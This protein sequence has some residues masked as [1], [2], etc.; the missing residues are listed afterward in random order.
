MK[1]KTSIGKWI[2]LYIPLLSIGLA[3]LFLTPFIEPEQT[4]QCVDEGITSPCKI[5]DIS[6]YE[7]LISHDFNQISDFDSCVAN[8]GTVQ[9]SF[10]RQ[11]K[12]PDGQ[13]FTES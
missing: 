13:I 3:I 4:I 2:F 12:T 9:N 5:A 7:W 10:P 6:L 11:C 1:K 8:T